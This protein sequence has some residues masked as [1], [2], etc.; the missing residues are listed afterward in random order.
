[1]FLPLAALFLVSIAGYRMNSI[2]KI[3]LDAIFGTQNF[4]SEIAWERTGLNT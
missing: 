1:M 4:L 2:L 3:L